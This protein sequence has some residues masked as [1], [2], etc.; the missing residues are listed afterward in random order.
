LLGLATVSLAYQVHLVAQ[1][2]ATQPSE[3]SDEQRHVLLKKRDALE[4]EAIE[5]DKQLL[6]QANMLQ[7]QPRVSDL[8]VPVTVPLLP[9]GEYFATQIFGCLELLD[10]LP[11]PCDPQEAPGELVRCPCRKKR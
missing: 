6:H 2:A 1:E 8:P 3:K 7:R 4:K 11:T 9:D 5:R 10:S